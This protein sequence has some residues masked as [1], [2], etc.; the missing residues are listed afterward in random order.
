MLSLI[1]RIVSQNN[2]QIL[3]SSIA[4]GIKRDF[5]VL[6]DDLDRLFVLQLGDGTRQL[7]VED[8]LEEFMLNDQKI[9][10]CLAAIVGQ[11]WSWSI[12]F[13]VGFEKLKNKF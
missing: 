9:F 4:V 7:L 11:G 12:F 3:D 5:F 2:Y 13:S 1:S 10:Q 6:V 8:W